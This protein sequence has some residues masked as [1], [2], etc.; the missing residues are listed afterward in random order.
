M[1]HLRQ[2]LLILALLFSTTALKA[3]AL[4]NFS[5]ADGNQYAGVG[6][7]VYGASSPLDVTRALGRAPD[8]IVKAEWM[9]PVIENYYYHDNQDTNA[10]ATVFV[11][12]GGL[13]AGMYFMT[14]QKQLTDIT[15]M[16]QENGDRSLNRDLNA[17]YLGFY[18]SLPYLTSPEWLGLR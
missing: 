8:N 4:S 3:S 2:L 15:F 6:E 9:F 11:F 10:P 16:L 18:P 7:L 14:A 13:L 17:G 5:P 12:E 1:N